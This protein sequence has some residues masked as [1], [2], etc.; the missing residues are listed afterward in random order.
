EEANALEQRVRQLMQQ[1]ERQ[2]LTMFLG[3]Q[4]GIVRFAI[5]YNLDDLDRLAAGG[6][7]EGSLAASE[8]F[9]SAMANVNQEAISAMYV[10]FP[11]ML[12]QA[13]ESMQAFGGPAE[14]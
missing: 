3:N 11:G 13:E 8:A 9:R 14:Q 7:A 6:G 12:A 10:D 2:Q 5:G 1:A 4:N